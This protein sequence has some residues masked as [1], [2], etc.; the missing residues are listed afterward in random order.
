MK[1]VAVVG[2]SLAGLRAVEALRRRGYDGVVVWI[3]AEPAKPY[4]RP[5]LSKQILRGEWE[6][7]RAA[8]KANYDALEVELRLGCRAVSL[9]AR[10]RQLELED[11]SRVAYDGLVIATGATPRNLRG[12]ASLEGVHTLRTLEDAQSIRR[13]LAER[14]RVAIVGA[15]FIGLEVAASCRALGLEVTVVERERVPLAAAIGAELGAALADFHRAQG[16]KLL[17]SVGVRTFVGERRVAGLELADGTIVAA[18]LVV[19]GIGVVPETRWLESSGLALDD[20]VVCD[21]RCA[22]SAP[23]VVA[24][25][26]VARFRHPLLRRSLRVEHWSN[27]V[28]QADAAARRLLDGPSATPYA[29]VPYFWSDQYD[30]KLQFAGHVSPDDELRVV[31]G[32]VATKNLIALYGRESKLEAALTVN[33]PAALVKYRRALAD[34]AAF[35]PL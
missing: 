3:G 26:D 11:G 18:D 17:T 32:S 33:K 19:V 12:A 31:E 14:P 5:P 7:G 28:E 34:G 29:P 21:E 23:G 30:L 13:A 16:V 27:A 1:R 22:A 2:A 10:E 6:D 24:C 8:L 4:D 25:G 20:G 15:G 35:E 9:D